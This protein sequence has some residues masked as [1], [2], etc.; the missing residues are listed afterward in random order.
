MREEGRANPDGARG[1]RWQQ[2]P[3]A[4]PWLPTS[5]P[6]QGCFKG[7]AWP[8]QQGKHLTQHGLLLMVNFIAKERQGKTNDP[9]KI[10]PLRL[11]ILT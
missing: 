10:G 11:I 2:R 3:K 4:R 9:P 5:P 7:T 1:V 8:S 6:P